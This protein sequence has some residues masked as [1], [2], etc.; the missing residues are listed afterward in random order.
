M[1]CLICNTVNPDQASY[2]FSCGKE[3]SR[4][5]A[6]HFELSAPE[7]I[8]NISSFGYRFLKKIPMP[9]WIS[10]IILWQ[11][12][13]AGDFFF[14]RQFGGPYLLLFNFFLYSTFAGTMIIIEYANRQMQDFFPRLTTFVDAP[15]AEIRTWYRE[16][17]HDAFASRK[18][19]TCGIIFAFIGAIT[20][21]EL[22]AAKSAGV[23]EVLM[24]RTVTTALGFFFQGLG[25]WALYSII[26]LANQLANFKINVQLF[27]VGNDSVMALGNVFLRM[28]FAI[29]IVYCLFILSDLVGGL[30]NSGIIIFWNIVAAFA[31][32][33]FF[34]MPQYR[35]HKLMVKEK[36][37]RL[38]AFSSYLEKMVNESLH[39]PTRE[40]L[41]H[42]KGLFELK[43]HLSKM[44]EWSFRTNA[45]S[46]LITVLLIPLLLALFEVY[47]SK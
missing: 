32:L 1:T 18:A 15:Q 22:L 11:L 42:L 40:K 34:I 26:T 29:T 27:A 2:C 17:L 25:L 16:R 33:C 38:K 9:Y 35:I 43:D 36:H 31:I 12:I 30:L 3:I 13:L 20:T 14:V 37:Q 47:L 28:S 4:L 7:E 8:T 21:H 23:P 5:K 46:Q 6:Q 24:Y 39:D 19:L 41:D 10:P 44:H 45:I